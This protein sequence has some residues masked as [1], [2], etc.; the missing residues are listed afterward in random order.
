MFMYCVLWPKEFKLNSR[1]VYYL[2]LYS[3]FFFQQNSI[4]LIKIDHIM[5]NWFSS[6]QC[7]KKIK[8]NWHCEQ[9]R[10]YD[11]RSRSN[12]AANSPAKA[13]HSA[14]A[15]YNKSNIMDRIFEGSLVQ[16][17]LKLL[18]HQ[19]MTGEAIVNGPN[20]RSS[21]SFPIRFLKRSMFS[22]NYFSLLMRR[23]V[24]TWRQE[25]R[26]SL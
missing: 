16:Q 19:A 7:H 21:L 13:L 11:Q 24:K 8:R 2:R 3:D 6:N 23:G 1:P 18:C 25:I 20:Y 10:I 5:S 14:I 4:P 22:H 15:Q 26:F 9:A 12:G 17:Q